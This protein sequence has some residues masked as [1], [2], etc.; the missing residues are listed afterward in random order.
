MQVK[1]KHFPEII[2]DN[3]EMYFAVL[4]GVIDSVDEL[5]SLQITKLKDGYSFRLSPSLPKYNNLLIEEI[6]KLNNVFG[7]HLDMS[8][9]IKSSGTLVFKIS[10]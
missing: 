6:I 4:H 2:E 8:K 1:R 3:E 5:S 7:I 10:I 9:S